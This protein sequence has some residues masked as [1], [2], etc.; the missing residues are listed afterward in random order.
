MTA[1]HDARRYD[2]DWLRVAAFGILIFY[3]VGMFYVTWGWHVKSVHTGDGA[4]WLMR[5]VNPWRLPLLFFISGIALRFVADAKPLAALARARLWRLGVPI[6]FGMA[7]VVAPQ[8]WFELR[9]T[10]EFTG[11]FAAF[12]PQY[13]DPTSPFSIITPTW[14]HLWYVVYILAYTLLLIPLARPLASLMRGAGKRV[15]ARIFGGRAG[16]LW[17]LLVLCVPQIAIDIVLADRF[18]V[19]H[20]LVADWANHAHCLVVFATGFVLAKKRAFWGAVDRGLPAIGALTLVLTVAFA[21]LWLNWDA[22]RATV[23]DSVALSATVRATRIVA[24]WATILTALGLAQRYLNR[25]SRAL[26][27]ATEAVFPWYILHQTILVAAGVWL[28][29]LGLSVIVE[30]TLVTVCVVAGSAIIHE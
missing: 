29:G 18:P 6:V 26:T 8:A 12:Y 24:A 20:N 30:V 15:C 16:I 1:I 23:V 14:N 11:S 9:A 28:T 17:A 2:L 22:I 5:L 21:L 10:G 27:Y 7:V 4:E 25:P 19:T 13:L 3:H